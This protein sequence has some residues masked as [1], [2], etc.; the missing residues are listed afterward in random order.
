MTKNLEANYIDVHGFVI[1][2]IKR[3]IRQ[4]IQALNLTGLTTAVRKMG[5]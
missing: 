1:E 3:P 4:Y 5:K 2:S